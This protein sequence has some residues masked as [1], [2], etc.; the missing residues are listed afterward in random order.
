MS[1]AI[2]EYTFRHKVEWDDFDYPAEGPEIDDFF[3]MMD[4]DRNLWELVDW[5]VTVA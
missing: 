5:D 2:I 1:S 3:E 4:G